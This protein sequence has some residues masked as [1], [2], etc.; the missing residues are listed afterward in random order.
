MRK[1]IRKVKAL[2]IPLFEPIEIK[3]NDTQKVL[4]SP[5]DADLCRHGWQLHESSVDRLYVRR[6]KKINGQRRW[7]WMHRVVL[8]RKLGRKLYLNEVPDHINNNPLDNRREN[9]RAITR[10]QNVSITM[11]ANG[12][13]LKG[14]HYHSRDHAWSSSIRID[15]KFIYL[16]R[17]D[18]EE[19]AHEAYKKAHRQYYGG[20]SPY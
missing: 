5:E 17:F 18:T 2:Q 15:G 11:T 16:G 13:H 14:A 12:G 8:E 4:V 19:A 9:L 1:H 6:R 10:G 3:L 7:L 20:L